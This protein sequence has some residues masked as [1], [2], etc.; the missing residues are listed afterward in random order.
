MYLIL[1]LARVLAYVKDNLVLS[2]KEGGR[3]ALD[4]IPATYHSLVE[5]AMREYAKGTDILY[6]MSLA[7]EYAG[8]MLKQI[9]NCR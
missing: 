7:K 1:N 6:D 5:D 2:K 4:N 8:Y 3:W 9:S